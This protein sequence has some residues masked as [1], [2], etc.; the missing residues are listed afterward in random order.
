MEMCQN[1]VA[2]SN[3]VATLKAKTENLEEYRDKQNGAL[4]RLTE[5]MEDM[6]RWLTGLLGGMVVS[7]I[8]LVINLVITYGMRR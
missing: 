2:L 5:Q 3:D 6:R 1:H 7:L 8:L 4:L